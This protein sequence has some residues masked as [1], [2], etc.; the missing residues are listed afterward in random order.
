M[1]NLVTGKYRDPFYEEFTP[2]VPSAS[3]RRHTSSKFHAVAQ[4]VY[5]PAEMVIHFS[6]RW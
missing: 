2:K 5:M 4:A 6:V 3:N 1:S